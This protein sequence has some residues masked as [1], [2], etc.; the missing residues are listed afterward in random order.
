MRSPVCQFSF[1]FPAHHLRWVCLI[2]FAFLVLPSIS[3]LRAQVSKEFQIKAV[4]LFRLSQFVDWPTNRFAPPESPIIIGVMGEN[5]FGDALLAAVQGETA[6]NRP[7]KII[8]V[9]S[10]EEARD[11]HILFICGSEE[12]R[13]KRI[14][15]ALADHPVLT[16][17]DIDDF[18]RGHGGMVRFI[19]LENKVNLRINVQRARAVGLTLHS[20]LLRMAE[21]VE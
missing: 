5:P 21:V 14:I 13:I 1:A 2:L 16:V 17:S 6:H 19:T 10:D 18:A 3:V 11:C 9:S 12:R 15:A 4:L 20:R 8:S 7:L